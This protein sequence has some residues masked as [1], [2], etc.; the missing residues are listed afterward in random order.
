MRWSRVLSFLAMLLVLA[1]ALSAVFPA[2]AQEAVGLASSSL[3]SRPAGHLQTEATERVEILV[4]QSYHQGYKWTDDVNAG[5]L[6]VLTGETAGG[7]AGSAGESPMTGSPLTT[8]QKIEVQ[9]EYMDTKRIY[10]KEYVQFLYE[11]YKYKF[12]DRDFAV[13]ISSDDEAFAF[14]LEYRDEIWP[15]TPV[16]FCGVNYF[17]PSMLDEVAS[18]TGEAPLFTGVNEEADIRSGLELALSLHPDTKIV[19]VVNEMTPTGRKVHQQLMEV[20]PDFEDRVTFVFLEAVD[21][22]DIQDTIRSLPPDSL[23]YYTTFL[24][25]KSGVFWEYDDS[26][27]AV[28]AAASSVRGGP[29]PVY[30]TW[31]FS[32]GYG[33]VGGMLTSGYYQG[34][35]AARLALRILEGEPVDQIPVVMESP[36][37]YMFD[38]EQLQRFEISEESLPEDSVIVNTPVSFLAQYRNWILGGGITMLVL[39]AAV[40]VLAS[41]NLRRRRAEEALRASNVELQEMRGSLEQRVAERTDALDRRSAQLEAAAEVAREALAIRDVS[42]L[43][44]ETVHLISERMGFYHAGIFLVDEAHYAGAQQYAVL[45]SASS[46]GGKHMLARGH[47][48]PLGILGAAAAKPTSGL[49]PTGIVGYVARTG[50]SRIALDVGQDAVFFDNPDLPLTRSEMALPLKIRDR[51]IGVLD[52]QST[53]AGAFSEEDVAILQTLADE[54]ALALENARLLEETQDRLREISA[55]A[56]EQERRRWRELKAAGAV[57][58]YVYDGVDTAP[59]TPSHAGQGGVERSDSQDNGASPATE[60]SGQDLLSVPL[61]ARDQVIGHLDLALGGRTPSPE[62][63][64]M[65]EAV[66]LRVGQALERAQLFQETQQRALRDQ[67][68]REIVENIRSAISVEDAVRRAIREMGRTLGASEVIARVGSERE[69]LSE[70]REHLPGED[71]HE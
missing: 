23:V 12:S 32:L 40:F 68:A 57:Q 60:H 38:Y 28:T 64:E 34:E 55:L 48:L 16:V 33:I 59:K 61:R 36:N 44:D 1:V 43:L 2:Q 35:T 18:P 3:R 20:L 39:V 26:I 41:A 71:G 47:Q 67:L 50:Q 62:E 51:I 24:R 53:D 11:T 54:V 65:I 9:I 25:D 14:L 27:L 58:G 15:G 66:A 22:K 5:I 70:G 30:G 42:L 63:V 21:M 7:A 49:A 13:I 52:V 8:G 29:F 17:E 19:A 56:V 6:S 46:E 31:D 4:L 45:R 37:R 10:D 69:L